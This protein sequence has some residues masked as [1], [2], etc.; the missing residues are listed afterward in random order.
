[1][2]ETPDRATIARC[3]TALLAACRN[4]DVRATCA[5]KAASKGSKYVAVSTLKPV[6]PATAH[7]VARAIVADSSG[8][9]SDVNV[10]RGFGRVTV[11]WE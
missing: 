7:D 8:T 10:H 6:K 5:T 1:M 11:S 4:A 2:G 3:N 9:I